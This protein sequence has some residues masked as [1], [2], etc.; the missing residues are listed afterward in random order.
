[1]IFSR[2]KRASLN[3]TGV[4]PV[5]KTFPLELELFFTLPA[6]HCKSGFSP[7]ILWP[8]PKGSPQRNWPGIS[9]LHKKPHGTWGTVSGKPANEDKGK[10]TGTVEADETYPDLFMNRHGMQY[11]EAE[12]A[13]E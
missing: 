4:V 2:G 10:F 13:S 8:G 11:E 6:Y 9:V 7:Y 3:L 12:T 1:M 5:E